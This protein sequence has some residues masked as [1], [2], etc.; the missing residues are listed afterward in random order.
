MTTKRKNITTKPKRIP[1][2]FCKDYRGHQKLIH[3]DPLSV[4]QMEYSQTIAR[5]LTGATEVSISTICRYAAAL[6][7]REFSKLWDLDD[8]E[9]EEH[10]EQLLKSLR[11]VSK[12][13]EGELVV[14][15]LSKFGKRI[16]PFKV[17]WTK[18]AKEPND[19][20]AC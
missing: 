6:L 7:A 12:G 3:L 4:A 5:K 18:G 2:L 15:D 9:L 1:A 20:S 16:P 19:A 13:I 17:L 8:S 14:D 10:R 11:M